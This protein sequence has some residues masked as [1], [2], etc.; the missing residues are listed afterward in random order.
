MTVQKIKDA[1]RAR[2]GYRCVHCGMSQD[3]HLRRYGC[4][5]HVHRKR[6]GS[7]YTQAGSETV[8]FSCHGPLPRRAWG[9]KIEA[10]RVAGRPL[11]LSVEIRRQLFDALERCRRAKKWTRRTAVEEALQQWLAREGFPLSSS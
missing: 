7:K 5:L 10:D 2:D 11:T 4:R 3:E 8:C 1:V 9:E 6:P